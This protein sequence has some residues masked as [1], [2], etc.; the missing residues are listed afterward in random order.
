MEF[1]LLQ[2]LHSAE[3]VRDVHTFKPGFHIVL[4]KFSGNGD[5]TATMWKRLWRNAD[6]WGDRNR[7]LVYRTAIICRENTLRLRCTYR[8]LIVGTSDFCWR[9]RDRGK[10]VSRADR[11]SRS[12]QKVLGRS[13]LSGRL[14]K[15]GFV[16]VWNFMLA[17]IP[18][19][20]SE[21]VKLNA[22]L[23]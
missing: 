16:K 7:L 2:I 15:P 1:A 8:L 14:W 17:V 9:P 12:S 13:R 11:R 21:R 18:M 6:D 20:S 19:L 4:R 22:K 10:P 3:E 23:M 5:R